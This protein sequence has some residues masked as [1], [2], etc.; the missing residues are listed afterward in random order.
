MAKRVLVTGGNGCIGK[1]LIP[2]LLA[3]GYSVTNVDRHDVK[4]LDKS[5][6]GYTFIHASIMDEQLFNQIDHVDFDTVIHLAA[7]TNESES[8]ERV[9]DFHTTN[10]SGCLRMLEYA[11]K[12]GIKHFILPS[13]GAVRDESGIYV[14]TPRS[15]YVANKMAAEQFAE[16]HARLHGL[17]ITILRLFSLYG[18]GVRSRLQE[19]IEAATQND[20]VSL[21][22]SGEEYYP[23]KVNEVVQVIIGALDSKSGFTVYELG[24]AQSVKDEEVL[25]LI[26]RKLG[27]DIQSQR[28]PEAPNYVDL[29]PMSKATVEELGLEAFHSLAEG[30][31]Q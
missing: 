30:L 6:A 10:V 13:S 22:R 1:E 19:V 7:E 16:V 26:G 18:T 4:G 25:A 14:R 9:L 17:D 11:R 3:A 31:Q 24:A 28:V 8:F 23:I 29:K 2:Q 15:P 20:V 12:R 21:G 27:K 5:E